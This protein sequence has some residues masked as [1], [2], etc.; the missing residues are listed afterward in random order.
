MSLAELRLKAAFT[1]FGKDKVL[2]DKQRFNWYLAQHYAS[3]SPIMRRQLCVNAFSASSVA[4]D[5]IN[6]KI[7]VYL[8]GPLV[9]SRRPLLL[10]LS[11]PP[12]SAPLLRALFCQY[13]SS[14]PN[15]CSCFPTNHGFGRSHL[16]SSS[17][18][19]VPF[20]QS[21]IPLNVILH[22]PA[23]RAMAVQKISSRLTIFRA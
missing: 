12:S 19:C 11:S 10:S 16:S 7:V 18:N 22:L 23:D 2:E 3:L 21:T 4:A 9:L 6:I 5:V 1:D 8:A 20:L 15:S 14:S 17:N 13:S